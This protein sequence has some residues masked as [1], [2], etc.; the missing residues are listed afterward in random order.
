MNASAI[1]MSL[2][3]HLSLL[4]VVLGLELVQ[5]TFNFGGNSI[6]TIIEDE[7]GV[8]VFQLAEPVRD[9]KKEIKSK[10]QVEHG[11]SIKAN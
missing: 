10:M 5:A 9:H 8:F 3:V 7:K 2:K 6:I 4:T 11:K 1:K